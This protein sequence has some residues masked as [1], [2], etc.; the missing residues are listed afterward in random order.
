MKEAVIRFEKIRMYGYLCRV[1]EGALIF[2]NSGLPLT[3]MFVLVFAIEIQQALTNRGNME[4]I[5]AIIGLW[6]YIIFFLVYISLVLV[7]IGVK[8]IYDKVKMNQSKKINY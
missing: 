5:D 1:L 4:F 2:Y 7:G 6:G 3:F 8:K